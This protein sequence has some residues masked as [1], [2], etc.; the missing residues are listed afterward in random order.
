MP[1]ILLVGLAIS[2]EPRYFEPFRAAMDRAEDTDELGSLRTWMAHLRTD[3]ASNV[4]RELEDR[5]EAATQGV[6][7][8]EEEEAEEPG[9]GE[10]Q[11]EIPTLPAS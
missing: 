1:A 9:Q 8:G 3:E 4:R 10:P 11:I 7:E 6:Q 2:G 5:I